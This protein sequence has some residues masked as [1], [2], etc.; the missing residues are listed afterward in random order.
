MRK[1]RKKEKEK[2]TATT[3]PTPTPPPPPPP[4]TTTTTT[5]NNNNQQSNN[6]LQHTVPFSKVPLQL[7]PLPKTIWPT[8]KQITIS[9]L[10]NSFHY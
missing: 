7:F 3:K 5:N 1:E 8:N 10:T 4:T 2:A 9:F 6:T